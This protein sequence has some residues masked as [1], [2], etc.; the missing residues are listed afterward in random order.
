M[1]GSGEAVCRGWGTD[2]AVGKWPAGAIVQNQAQ[3]GHLSI[4]A[5]LLGSRGGSA[6]Q[7]PA[8]AAAAGEVRCAAIIAST[9][10]S[11]VFSSSAGSG[12]LYVPYAEQVSIRAL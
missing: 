1:W 12:M 5:S 4:A 8:N 7:R 10:T 9:R 2:G 3:A 6:G 11:S